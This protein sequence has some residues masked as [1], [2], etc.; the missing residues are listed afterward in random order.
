MLLSFHT[1][2]NMKFVYT[3]IIAIICLGNAFSFDSA[4]LDLEGSKN[5]DI[6]VAN[7]WVL[8]LL[9]CPIG[10]FLIYFWF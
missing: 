7:L 9:C 8:F 2:I 4:E 5:K 10:L 3:D 1:G 6:N